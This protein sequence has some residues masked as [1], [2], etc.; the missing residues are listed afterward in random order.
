MC[1]CV[2]CPACNI[3]IVSSLVGAREFL[4]SGRGEKRIDQPGGFPDVL[5]IVTLEDIVFEEEIRHRILQLC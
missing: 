1:E 4:H 3:A 2:T 5:E